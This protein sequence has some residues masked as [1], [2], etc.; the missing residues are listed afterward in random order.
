MRTYSF[1][2]FD[3]FATR[4]STGNPAASVYLKK[5]SELSDIEMLSIAKQLE[6]FVN[7]VAF[8]TQI[9]DTNFKLKYFSAEREVEFCGHATIGV[10]YNT[11]K[12][13]KELLAKDVLFI[14]T[15]KG[16]LPVYNS[17]NSEN[18]VYIGSPFPEIKPCPIPP[19]QIFEQLNL[20]VQDLDIRSF[21]NSKCRS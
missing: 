13:S 10:M 14:E 5:M 9:D 7:E 11:I 19:M 2:K 3:A 12:E 1:N 6:G 20:T 17:I 4:K 15:N 18:V 21:S 8:I 16:K